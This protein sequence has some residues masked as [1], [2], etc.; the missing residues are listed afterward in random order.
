[1][2]LRRRQFLRFFGIVCLFS[3]ATAC[4]RT[5]KFG[6]V[7]DVQYHP[8]DSLGTRYYSASLP[9]LRECA[10]QLNKEKLRFVLNLGDTIDHNFES[11]ERV[12]P[13]WKKLR[14]PVFHVLG[15]HDFD[16]PDASEDQVLS[17]LEMKRAYYSFSRGKWDFIVLHGFELR[18]PLPLNRDLAG[19]AQTLYLVLR[20]EGRENA[21]RW[22]GGV[23]QEQMDFLRR[24]LEK[25]DKSRRNV[26][27][28]C[29]FPVLPEA[30]HNLWNDREVVAL[31][32]NHSCVRAYFAG[33]N[34]AGDY[35]LR[36]GIHYLTFQGMVE[37]ADTAAFAVVTLK[38]DAIHVK[39]FGRE[40]SRTLQLHARPAR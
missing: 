5:V 6:V 9:K 35:A 17:A 26:I 24:E 31:L 34:H 13:V 32:Q 1:M 30:A 39:G 4:G 18:Y 16:F 10:V 23:G 3:L 12:L 28:F 19:E 11:F 27:V 25:S 40:P 29:H 37:T 33:H 2:N 15:N 38:K 36:D 14:P 7:A 20:A 22:N 21:Q 8:S